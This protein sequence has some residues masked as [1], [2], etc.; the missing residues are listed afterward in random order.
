MQ[1]KADLNFLEEVRSIPEQKGLPQLYRAD[2]EFAKSKGD[3]AF[4]ALIEQIEALFAGDG[5]E[6]TSID[7]RTHMLMEGMYPCIPGWHCDDF[8]R[9]NGGQPDLENVEKEAPQKHYLIVLGDCSLTEF[10]KPGNTTFAP[11]PKELPK[12]NPCYFYYDKM[13]EED[14]FDTVFVEPNKIYSFGPLAFHRGSPATKNGFRTF[15]RL[16]RSNHRKPKNELRYQSNVYI[17]GRVSW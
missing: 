12:D 4:N 9:P 17:A 7:T 1:F 16:T 11:S 8:Y 6:H 2:L 14:K 3:T 13:F 15:I 10:I 5:F